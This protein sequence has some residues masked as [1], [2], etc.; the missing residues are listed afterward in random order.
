MIERE[1]Y[2]K[3]GIPYRPWLDAWHTIWEKTGGKGHTDEPLDIA[4][5]DRYGILDDLT[6]HLTEWNRRDCLVGQDE[7]YFR[8]A[9]P[10]EARIIDALYP[11]SEEASS[12][13]NSV[14][15]FVETENRKF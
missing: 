12:F 8:Q 14:I 13:V 3:N 11:D 10:W 4:E 1:D 2:A 7:T 5:E 6:T 15:A 9:C